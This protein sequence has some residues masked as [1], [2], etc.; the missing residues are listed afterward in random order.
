MTI[1]RAVGEAPLYAIIFGMI[2]D[3]VEFGQWKN[4]IRQ[5]SLIFACGSMGFKVGT[6]IASA[7]VSALL[8]SAG[9]LSSTE[10][11]V[12]QP[13][14]ALDMIHSIYAWAPIIIWGIVAAVLLFYHLDKKYPKIMADLA[15]R[16][17]R[18]E[19]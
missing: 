19:M 4:H 11:G 14:S 3:T 12:A 15:E 2:G 17:A 13:Q 1:I 6:G 18:G 5:E 16:E 8:E 9:Y 7:L 10:G